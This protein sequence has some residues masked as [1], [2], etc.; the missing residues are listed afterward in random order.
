[1]KVFINN[2]KE[3]TTNENRAFSPAPPDEVHS[4]K[5]DP[6]HSPT[7]SKLR[8]GAEREAVGVESKIAA[9]QRELTRKHQE[10]KSNIENCP[11]L[12]GGVTL[13]PT[14]NDMRLS[15]RETIHLVFLSTFLTIGCIAV[16]YSLHGS[17]M[18]RL[19]NSF[20]QLVN[21]HLQNALVL[22]GTEDMFRTSLKQ[23]H[24]SFHLLIISIE[25]AVNVNW[26]DSS[27]SYSFFWLSYFSGVCGLLYLFIESIFA[28]NRLSPRRIK[29]W[30]VLMHVLCVFRRYAANCSV[31]IVRK[32]LIYMYICQM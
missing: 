21:F 17:L 3:T 31:I 32:W 2:R 1:M 23:W 8:G 10:A 27:L 24:K 19:D 22:D 14:M 5:R 25:K 9:K 16:F 11:G 26:K 15:K 18:K 30:Y 4:S 6:I 29:V 20:H 13:W 12:G 7:L 28:R